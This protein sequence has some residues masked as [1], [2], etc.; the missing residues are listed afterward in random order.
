MIN[1]EKEEA[2]V[3]ITNAS[4]QLFSE[5]GYDATRVNEIADAAGVNKALIYYY[6]KSKQEILDHL[7]KTFFQNFKTQLMSFIEE[8]VV[9]MIK[10]GRLDIEAKRFHFTTKKDADD[11]MSRMRSYYEHFIDYLLE[12]RKIIRIL[13][14]ESLKKS[15]HHTSLFYFANIMEKSNTNP[16]FKTIYDADQDFDYSD[17]MVELKFFFSFIPML[18]FAAYYDIWKNIRGITDKVL[19]ESF[20]G[21][22]DMTLSLFRSGQDIIIER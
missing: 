8:N 15:K 12:N 20:L 5:K 17:S 1:T 9:N 19:R 18:S 2:K 4:I 22:I 6:F 13:L 14:L 10:N 11:F 7:L 21:S 16:F 3:R